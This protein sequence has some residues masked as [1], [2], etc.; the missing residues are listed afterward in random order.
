ML[1]MKK[2]ELINA[3]GCLFDSVETTSFASARLY[4]KNNYSGKF[5]IVCEGERKVVNL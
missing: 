3:E 1:K 4:F 2:Y 5:I